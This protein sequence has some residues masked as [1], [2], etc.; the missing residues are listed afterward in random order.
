MANLVTAKRIGKHGGK[1]DPQTKK[2]KE[3]AK[4]DSPMIFTRIP[5]NINK[6]TKQTFLTKTIK[7]RKINKHAYQSPVSKCIKILC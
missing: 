2:T 4:E 6:H 7:E 1:I 5:L 3:E